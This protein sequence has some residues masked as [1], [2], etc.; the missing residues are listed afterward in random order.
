MID[1]NFAFNLN[2]N[3]LLRIESPVGCLFHS[4]EVSATMLLSEN[5][6]VS[7]L[8]NQFHLTKYMKNCIHIIWL[9][10]YET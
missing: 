2:F 7:N 8:W 1:K 10:L 3:E 6:P 4:Q 5:I 9:I